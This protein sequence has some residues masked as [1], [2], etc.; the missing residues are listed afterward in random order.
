M[1]A[2]HPVDVHGRRDVAQAVLRQDDDLYAPRLVEADEIAAELVDLLDVDGRRR[3][4][5][6]NALQVVVEVRE[7][8]E[9]ERWRELLLDVLR[10]LGNPARRLD[11]R[12][13]SPETEERKRP[14]LRLQLVAKSGGRGVDVGQLPAV[15][16]IHRPRRDAVVR[17][18]IHVVPP[19]EVGARERR[20]GRLRALPDLR[21][22]HEPVRL[23]PELDLR[24][25]ARVPA[26]ADDAVRRG[27]AAGQ[28][29]GLGR[30]GDGGK[31]G[32][33]ARKRSTRGPARQVRRGRGPDDP[34]GQP[35]DVED[36]RSLH[37]GDLPHDHGRRLIR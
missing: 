6:P 29:V 4:A 11:G 37:L 30:A 21:R 26:V 14:E 13:R 1:L 9:R 12:F 7:I 31:R 5:R 2:Q 3:G 28:V 24:V 18:R 22:L 35:D 25:L 10:R 33:N 17:G 32:S 19:E 23:L 15:G 20:V 8:D 36:G 27:V 16:E 34:R